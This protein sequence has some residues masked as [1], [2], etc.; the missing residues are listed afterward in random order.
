MTNI[1]QAR[2]VSLFAVWNTGASKDFSEPLVDCVGA[3]D[4][5]VR[6][7]EKEIIVTQPIGRVFPVITQQLQ[8]RLRK[9][10]QSVPSVFGFPD[11]KDAFFQ[12]YIPK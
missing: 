6:C 8:Q 10:D 1:M 3:E 5:A 7:G 9:R 4:R 12:I 2:S 11:R